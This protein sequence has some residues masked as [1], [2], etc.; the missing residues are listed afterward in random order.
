MGEVA[1]GFVYVEA[2]GGDA[3]AALAAEVDA[4]AVVADVANPALA[5]P[6]LV[7]KG[8]LAPAHERAPNPVRALALARDFVQPPEVSRPPDPGLDCVV[9]HPGIE[10]GLQNKWRCH[11]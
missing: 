2:E 5:H 4:V 1:A 11:L 10:L 6:I 8:G 7:N 3:G 9:F